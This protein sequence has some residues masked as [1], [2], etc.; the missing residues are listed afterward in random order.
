MTLPSIH[1]IREALSQ[2]D[3]A[4]V[5]RP[6]TSRVDIGDIPCVPIS[7]PEEVSRPEEDNTLLSAEADD[8]ADEEMPSVP[9]SIDAEP[10]IIFEV[11]PELDDRAVEKQLGQSPGSDF[12]QLI[13]AHGIDALGWYFPFHYQ[14]AQHG[15]YI[16]SVG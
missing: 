11:P 10:S 7:R 16:S 15:I 12:E 13:K 2:I 6:R 8:A 4:L 5:D 14:I 1:T 9:A 3:G